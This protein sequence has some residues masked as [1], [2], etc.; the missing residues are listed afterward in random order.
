MR[1]PDLSDREFWG[2]VLAIALVALV[3][4]AGWIIGL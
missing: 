4:F 3:K 1:L 2:N